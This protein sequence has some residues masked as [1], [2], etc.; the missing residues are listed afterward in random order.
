MTR[1]ENRSKFIVYFSYS[2]FLLWAIVVDSGGIIKWPVCRAKIRHPYPI[3][4]QSSEHSLNT[5]K[6]LPGHVFRN[7]LTESVQRC[8][9]SNHQQTKPIKWKCAG[10]LALIDLP[11][12]TQ[13]FF[14]QTAQLSNFG[15]EPRVFLRRKSR[16][17]G[18]LF[19]GKKIVRRVR[20]ILY[21]LVLCCCVR[22]GLLRAVVIPV[23][24]HFLPLAQHTSFFF[25]RSLRKRPWKGDVCSNLCAH[26][27]SHQ[28]NHIGILVA[29]PSFF[30]AK[31][32]KV[33]ERRNEAPRLWWL[34]LGRTKCLVD[35]V[36][37]IFV[38]LQHV[39]FWKIER[40]KYLL[41]KC[42]NPSTIPAAGPHWEK[43]QKH[44]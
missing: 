5:R 38:T 9:K 39:R 16:Q 22:Q 28:P 6:T 26:N 3:C 4:D 25:E 14:P 43:H 15:A 13:F 30:E 35:R 24:F 12:P 37:K 2:L 29:G 23:F 11:S 18:R 20:V 41:T 36:N 19:S 32:L 8:E 17:M 34:K 31:Q 33:V 7:Q 40:K 10:N 42:K 1:F 44:K 27:E 21:F